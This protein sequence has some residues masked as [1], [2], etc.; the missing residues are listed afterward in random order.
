[1]NGIYY[2][3]TGGREVEHFSAQSSGLMRAGPDQRC[4]AP[5]LG[6]GDTK[7]CGQARRFADK[8]IKK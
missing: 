2:G 3:K 1:M 6:M 4:C 5:G 8:K 7:R